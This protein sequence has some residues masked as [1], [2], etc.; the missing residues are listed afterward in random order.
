MEDEIFLRIYA[1]HA[2]VFLEIAQ[3]QKA[4]L[5]ALEQSRQELERLNLV[6][7]KALDHLAH[8]LK[9]PLAVIQGSLRVLKRKIT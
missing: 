4:R 2:A 5:E 3:L 8:E 9:T 7:D 1:N 6:K